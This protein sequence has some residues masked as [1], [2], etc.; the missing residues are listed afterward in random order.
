MNKKAQEWHWEQMSLELGSPVFVF[1][2]RKKVWLEGSI[3]N[4]THDDGGEWLEIQY[5]GRRTKQV[6]RFSDFVRPRKQ[7]IQIKSKQKLQCPRRPKHVSDDKTMT[8]Q[9]HIQDQLYILRD[10]IT[11]LKQELK[12][13]ASTIDIKESGKSESFVHQKRE[14]YEST[15]RIQRNMQTEIGM[16]NA[17]L[18]K[19]ER[20]KWS[21][22]IASR[23][24]E[25]C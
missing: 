6:Q 23:Q 4:I 1:S 15:Q 9:E 5:A 22:W 12:N 25:H 18:A 14:G 19:L 17:R 3:A 20:Q 24:N 7:S 13:F 10:S 16:L 8:F 21:N 2:D 11:S